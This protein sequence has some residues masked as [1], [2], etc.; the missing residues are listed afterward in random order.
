MIK[1][2][3]CTGELT[4]SPKDQEVVCQYC[5]SKFNPKELKA[6]VKMAGEKKEK[7]EE[8]NQV[9][10]KSY[11]CS[12]CGAT[13]LTFDETAITFCSYCGSQAMIESKMMKINKPDF[14]IPFSKTKEQCEMAYKKKLSGAWFTPSYMKSDITIQKFRGI[15][16]PYAIYKLE[17]HGQTSNKGSK[18][19]HRSGDYVY[20]DDYTILAYVDA[21]YEGISYDLISKFY[22]KYSTAIPYNF[23]K[24]EDFNPNYLIGYYAD[25]GDVD[26][27]TYDK[28]ALKV[29][30]NDITKRLKSNSTFHKYGCSNPTMSLDVTERKTGMFPVYFLAIK[31]KENERINYAIVNGQTGQVVADLPISFGKYVIGSLVLAL[32]IFILID[33][34]ITLTPTK[35]TFFSIAASLMS[36]I[37]SNKQA[38]QINNHENHINDKGYKSIDKTKKRNKYGTFK[39]IW[40][41]IISVIIPTTVL[42]VNPVKDMYYYGASL[43]SLLFVLLSFYDLVKEHNIL[44]TSK[45]PQLEKRG[46]DE[47]EK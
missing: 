35:V 8:K 6:R 25:A 46:G 24:K 40:K 3:N 23:K 36:F 20:Y 45:P 32:I 28:D 7:K 27:T 47:R 38:S 2:P 33:N 39:Y 34:M 22:D 41:E 31:N 30:E 16:I 21:S 13:L 11:T 18:Y 5:G 19:S 12:Q 43:I 1:C 37:I 44:T 10:G 42:I 26:S 4:F 17:H 15:Y 14:I 29:T 9:E